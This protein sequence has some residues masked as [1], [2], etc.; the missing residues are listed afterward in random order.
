VALRRGARDPWKDVDDTPVR[1]AIAPGDYQV[2]V[3]Y[4]PTGEVKERDVRLKPGDNPPVRFAF[5]RGA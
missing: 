2:R 3:T 4:V 1:K 5:R